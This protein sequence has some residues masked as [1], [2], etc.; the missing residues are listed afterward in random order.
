MTLLLSCGKILV[1]NY[2]LRL[3]GLPPGGRFFLVY[4]CPQQSISG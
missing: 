2:A 1:L 3:F 4:G